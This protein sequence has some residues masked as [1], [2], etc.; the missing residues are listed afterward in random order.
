MATSAINHTYNKYIS[1][2]KKGTSAKTSSEEGHLEIKCESGK[3]VIWV[4]SVLLTQPTSW[5]PKG[6]SV[7]VLGALWLMMSFI[8]A[9]VYESNLMAMLIAPKLEL[10][11]NSFEELG[12]TNFKVFLPFGSRIW[13]TINNAQETDFLYSSKK[14]IITSEDTQEG[15]DGYLAGKWGM[16]S[17]RDALTYGLHLD[18]SKS[19]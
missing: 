4:F 13:E 1:I 16:S 7:R 5:H 9:T 12:K 14:N 19:E 17:I 10:P 6:D 2:L 8:L 3:T 15:I 11:F 18:F